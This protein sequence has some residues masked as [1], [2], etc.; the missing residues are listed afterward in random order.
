MRHALPLLLGIWSVAA[1]GAATAPADG[2]SVVVPAKT[3]LTARM[4]RTIGTVRA[5]GPDRV[6]ELTRAGEEFTATV[7][8]PI[9]DDDGR[10]SIPAGAILQGRVAALAPGVGARPARL[11][12]TAE[13]LDG[14]E[15]RAH[16]VSAEV[17]LLPSSD[18]GKTADSAALAGILLGGIAFGLPGI[19]IGYGAGGT[20]AAVGAIQERRVEAWLSAGTLIAVELDEPLT[21]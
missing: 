3:R 7:T 14:K 19:M 21:R 8:T 13:R 17:E 2:A 9:V 11:E 12:L 10:Y 20:A 5:L 18:L 4:N 1:A 16:V 15:L 6:A